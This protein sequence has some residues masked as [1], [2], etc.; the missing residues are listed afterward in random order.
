MSS[1]SSSSRKPLYGNNWYLADEIGLRVCAL[2]TSGFAACVIIY[3]VPHLINYDFCEP[4]VFSWFGF[5]LACLGV[6][7]MFIICVGLFIFSIFS[8]WKK[9]EGSSY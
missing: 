3:I 4:K 6:F 5:I 2:L 8:K 1:R 7:I 9:S